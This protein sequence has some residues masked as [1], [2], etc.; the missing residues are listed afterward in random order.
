MRMRTQASRTS[1][2]ASSS[3][4]GCFV[5]SNRLRPRESAGSEMAGHVSFNSGTASGYSSHL[6]GSDRDSHD[7]TSLLLTDPHSMRSSLGPFATVGESSVQ[8]VTIPPGRTSLQ[9]VGSAAAAAGDQATASAAQVSSSVTPLTQ[10]QED[11]QAFWPK[12][13]EKMKHLT[14][15]DFKVMELPLA[16]IKKIMK[17]DDDV[18]NQMI[19]AEVPMLFSKAAEIFISELTLRSWIHTEENKRRTLQRN[20][21]A[22]AV[23][24]Y[25]QFDFLIDIVPRED[26]RAGRPRQD[27]SAEGAFACY[28]QTLQALQQQYNPHGQAGA[29]SDAA[30]LDPAAISQLLQSLQTLSSITAMTQQQN[31]HQRQQQ[32]QLATQHQQQQQHAQSLQDEDQE[33]AQSFQEGVASAS[34]PSVPLSSEQEFYSSS[35]AKPPT[36]ILDVVG[37]DDS[38]DRTTT[39]PQSAGAHFVHQITSSATRSATA[40]NADTA[41]FGM[42]SSLSYSPFKKT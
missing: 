26:W 39:A 2:C 41:D 14:Q 11:L 30:Q 24:R 16:R 36:P 31:L 19:S 29:G 25:D 32:Q 17:Q 35:A 13:N 28:L 20:D 23:G 10:C 27:Q 6:A 1:S 33:V 34:H 8:T 12:V 9:D 42:F 15:S 40:A 5:S 22:L 21:I 37:D 18:K 3:S 7:A 38:P 4:I